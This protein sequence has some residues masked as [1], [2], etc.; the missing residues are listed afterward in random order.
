MKNMVDAQS[1]AEDSLMLALKIW[2]RTEATDL[3]KFPRVDP[4][5]TIKT[6]EQD[7]EAALDEIITRY[8]RALDYLA[9]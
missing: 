4:R 8:P 3:P 7:L 5:L 9:K 1:R 2:N 6:K